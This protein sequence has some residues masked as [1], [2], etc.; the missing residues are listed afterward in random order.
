MAWIQNE[1]GGY[2]WEI[3]DPDTGADDSA[4]STEGYARNIIGPLG[5][6]LFDVGSDLLLGHGGTD[7]ERLYHQVSRESDAEYY[8]QHKDILNNISRADR[9]ILLDRGTLL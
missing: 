8:E 7:A 1:G 2:D 5:S 6:F 9:L 3:G 4:S